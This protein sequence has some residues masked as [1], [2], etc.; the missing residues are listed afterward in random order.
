MAAKRSNSGSQ[1]FAPNASASDRLAVLLPRSGEPGTLEVQS[2]IP[3]AMDVVRIKIQD[4][5][6]AWNEVMQEVSAV[7]ATSENTLAGYDIDSI[8]V[9]IGIDA[10]G[11]LGV[12]AVGGTA[13]FEVKF[14]RR[15]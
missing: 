5:G 7:L 11:N 12:I 2:L 14:Q 6:K 1:R 10:K 8:T 4:V 15:P 3:N 13:S 9:K